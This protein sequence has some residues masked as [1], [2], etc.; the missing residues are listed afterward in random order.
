VHWC[1][2]IQAPSG[3]PKGK[4]GRAKGDSRARCRADFMKDDC[5]GV[6]GET[7]VQWSRMLR[8]QANTQLVAAKAQ[9]SLELKQ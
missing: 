2:E 4:V 1:C 6:K 7:C 5:L 8:L 9:N 3:L